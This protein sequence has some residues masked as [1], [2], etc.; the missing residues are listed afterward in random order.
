MYISI[1]SSNHNRSQHRR[2]TG[3][4]FYRRVKSDFLV[5]VRTTSDFGVLERP[6][7]QDGHSRFVV[8]SCMTCYSYTK[9]PRLV[10]QSTSRRSLW[11]RRAGTLTCVNAQSAPLSRGVSLKTSWRAGRARELTLNRRKER[12]VDAV[13]YWVNAGTS[14]KS[15]VTYL[16][17]VLGPPL[18]PTVK[19]WV[20]VLGRRKSVQ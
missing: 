9:V 16:V 2:H 5:S 12:C 7:A 10:A 20:S 8:L 18:A 19:Y 1:N 14:T 17:S 6:L 4:S 3:V 15:T 11:Q 13:K